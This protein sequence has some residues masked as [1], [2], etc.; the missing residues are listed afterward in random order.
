M[1]I[2]LFEWTK[3]EMGYER[4]QFMLDMRDDEERELIRRALP[5]KT[6][7]KTA[8]VYEDRAWFVAKKKSELEWCP[9]MH[10]LEN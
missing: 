8:D 1:G 5:R 7:K 4:E 3:E 2:K 6:L 9:S 10:R